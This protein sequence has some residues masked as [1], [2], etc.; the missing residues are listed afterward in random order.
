[1]F[2]VAGPPGGGKS[3]LFA[4]SDFTGRVFNADDRAA[5]LNA[6]SY[7]RIPLSVRTVVNREFEE[8]IYSNIRSGASFAL[9][10]ALRSTI[11]FDQARFAKKHGFQVYMRYVALDTVEGHIERV[12]RRAARGGHSASEATLR[13]IHASSLSNL[14]LVLN[15]DKSGIEFVRIYD[16]SHFERLPHRVLEAR[17]GRLVWLGPDFPGWLQR[18]LG[19]THQDLDRNRADLTRKGDLG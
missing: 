7:Q 2:I 5:Q 17:G 9:E 4:L 19:W 18:A 3:S 8:F 1:M 6:G 14:P 13:Q 11:T 16:N 10:T 15:P 12:E